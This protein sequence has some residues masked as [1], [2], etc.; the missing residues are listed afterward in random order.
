SAAG[1][2]VTGALIAIT[3]GW[4]WLDPLVALVI[5]VVVGWHAIALVRTVRASPLAASRAV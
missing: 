3:G 5:S 2:A 4:Y 1:V